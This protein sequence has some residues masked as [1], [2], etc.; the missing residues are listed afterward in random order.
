M[1]VEKEKKLLSCKN[2]KIKLINVKGSYIIS[3]VCVWFKIWN[4]TN[5]G[6]FLFLSCYV[7]N[8]LPVPKFPPN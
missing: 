5:V 8:I 6:N 2:L 7:G 3:V 1:L 4:P